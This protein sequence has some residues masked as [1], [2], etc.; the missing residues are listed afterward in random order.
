VLA[1]TSIASDLLEN[2]SSNRQLLSVGH[3]SLPGV[4][5]HSTPMEKPVADFFCSETDNADVI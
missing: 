2:Q 4:E 1:K 3:L 5:V